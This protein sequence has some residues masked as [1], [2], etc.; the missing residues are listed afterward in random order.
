MY[1]FS[2]DSQTPAQTEANEIIELIK[3]ENKVLHKVVT[4]ERQNLK[5]HRNFM[6]VANELRKLGLKVNPVMNWSVTEW[7][8]RV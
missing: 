8:I 2:H 6:A 3:A 5:R 7:A 1:R 4:S